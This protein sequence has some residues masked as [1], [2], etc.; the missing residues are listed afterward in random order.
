MSRAFY[1]IH[2]NQEASEC[3]FIHHEN[4]LDVVRVVDKFSY[5]YN[6]IIKVHPQR[7]VKDEAQP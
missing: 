4:G 1:K 3:E 7:R 6:E 5:R 2:E